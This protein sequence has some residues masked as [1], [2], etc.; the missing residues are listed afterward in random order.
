MFQLSEM[1]S[2]KDTFWTFI[3]L[4]SHTNAF[5]Y[6]TPECVEV[7]NTIGFRLDLNK[8]RQAQEVWLI[9]TPQM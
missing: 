1:L 8:N 4:I 9:K 7:T 3:W 2:S 6:S 5:M